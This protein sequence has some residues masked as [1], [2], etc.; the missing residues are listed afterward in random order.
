MKSYEDNR[1]DNLDKK[2]I[3]GFYHRDLH[4][5]TYLARSKNQLKKQINGENDLNKGALFEAMNRRISH[6][7][8][9]GIQESLVKV[10]TKKPKPSP[11]NN[12][13][14][15]RSPDTTQLMMKESSITLINEPSKQDNSALN[16]ANQTYSQTDLEVRESKDFDRSR[17]LVTQQNTLERTPTPK[18]EPNLKPLGGIK[19]NAMDKNFDEMQ[20]AIELSPQDSLRRSIDDSRD[21]GRK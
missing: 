21:R 4:D 8:E 5:N 20:D 9:F 17:N 12:A 13:R 11:S 10:K 15:S 1:L 2:L 18:G 3:E 16:L 7:V 19:A 6:Q 14:D